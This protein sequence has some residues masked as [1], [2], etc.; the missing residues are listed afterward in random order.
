M[1]FIDKDEKGDI[2]VNVTHRVGRTGVNDWDDVTVVQAL[3][4]LVYSSHYILSKKKVRIE[5][6]GKPSLTTDLAIA[7]YQATILKRPKPE[8]YIN[9]LKGPKKIGKT[10][11]SLY[12]TAEFIIV[13]SGQFASLLQF[14]KVTYPK[15]APNLT[16]NGNNSNT[17]IEPSERPRRE[18]I[19]DW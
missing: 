2:F 6:T 12:N 9:S 1:A 13:G 17:P 4:D 15:L 8:G 19:K 14:L 5:V 7:D 16:G 3:L 11:W 10:I 18:R